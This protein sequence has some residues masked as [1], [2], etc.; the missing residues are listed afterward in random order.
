[1]WYRMRKHWPFLSL[2]TAMQKV[3]SLDIQQPACLPVNE[4]GKALSMVVESVFW[5]KLASL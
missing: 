3:D 5:L 4:L 2:Y 1:M